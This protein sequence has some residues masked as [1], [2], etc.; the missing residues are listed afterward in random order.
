[1]PTDLPEE[2]FHCAPQTKHTAR[3]VGVHRSCSSK[4]ARVRAGGVGRL[5]GP[6]WTKTRDFLES[7]CAQRK[8]RVSPCDNSCTKLLPDGKRKQRSVSVLEPRR[9]TTASSRRTPSFQ[10]RYSGQNEA[11]V[12]NIPGKLVALRRFQ[13]VPTFAEW[14]MGESQQRLPRGKTSWV[15]LTRTCL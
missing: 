1:M 3:D 6:T 4:Q 14:P 11:T 9:R 13:L 12:L 2:I 5:G 15:K 10:R 8:W 7:T